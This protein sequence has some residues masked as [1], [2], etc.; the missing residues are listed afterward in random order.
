MDVFSV[1]SDAPYRIEFFGDT[2]D[3][4]RTFDVITQRSVTNLDKVSISAVSD[5]VL[6]KDKVGSI[7]QKLKELLSQ[8]I[9]NKLKEN[10]E[11]DIEYIENNNQDN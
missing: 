11:K 4:I 9:G 6:S 8:N 2:V 10:I 7:I 3:S 1:Q 5:L